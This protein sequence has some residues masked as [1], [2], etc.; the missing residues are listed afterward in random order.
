MGLST[1]IQ[2]A[3]SAHEGQ[4]DKSGEPYILHPLRV[5][6][7]QTDDVSR[8]VGVLHDVAE[9]DAFGWYNIHDGGFSIEVIEAVDS[10]TRREGEDYFD[11]VARAKANPIGKMVKIADLND[12]MDP[13]RRP[14]NDPDY[15][16]R[17]AKY[18]RALCYLLDKTI[19]KEAA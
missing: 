4:V 14:A 6:L 8:I 13:S 16:T 12:N 15:A 9:D 7:A 18:N 10:V 1:A 5:M 11:Y 3:A 19:V 2:V 17:M